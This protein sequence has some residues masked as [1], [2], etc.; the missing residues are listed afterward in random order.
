M[1]D[2][3]ICNTP[4]QLFNA[5]NLVCNKFQEKESRP[6]IIVSNHSKV[7]EYEENLRQSELFE[8]VYYAQTLELSRS[9]YFFKDKKK[10][11]A[12]MNPQKVL[13]SILNINYCQY[14]RIFFANIEGYVNLIFR[15]V[16][17]QRE[18][19]LFE[20]YEDGWTSYTM[21]LS[22]YAYS[23][24]EKYF[25]ETL[26]NKILQKSIDHIWLYKPDLF[27]ANQSDSGKLKEIPQ[28]S[29]GDIK[30]KECVNQIFDYKD[31]LEYSK[32]N[33]FLEEA[34]SE[35]GYKNNDLELARAVC[36]FVGKQNFLLKRHPRLKADRWQNLGITTNTD[37][38]IPWEV[39]ILNNDF[40]AKKIFT[41][42]SNACMT[43]QLVFGITIPVFYLKKALKGGL[44][45]T[46][47]KREVDIFVS[48][49]I[50]QYGNYKFY[51]LSNIDELE[52]YYMEYLYQQQRDAF[53]S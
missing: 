10:H 46:Y 1:K 51:E 31:A 14:D 35:D 30:F 13:S 52:E 4:Y 7:S 48:K 38:K 37:V 3:F 2:L 53:F 16:I 6:D 22:V 9:F 43:P 27:C 26:H 11:S 49:F 5:V 21:N 8:N 28:I 12:L 19:V 45:Q 36:N 50:E 33:I 24:Y 42:S 34:F 25:Y 44:S 15:Y 41:V 18:D 17:T 39:L 20:Y 40:S 29:I 32:E 23:P 47:Q